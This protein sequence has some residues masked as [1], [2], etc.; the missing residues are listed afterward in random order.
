[1]KLVYKMSDA[2]APRDV[3]PPR[4]PNR[5]EGFALSAAPY[6][7]DREWADII[8]PEYSQDLQPR[9]AASQTQG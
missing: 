6:G 1:M 9:T 3:R 7:C 8:A 5:P 2:Y 4:W